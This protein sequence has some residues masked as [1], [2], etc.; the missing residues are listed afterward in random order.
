MHNPKSG[1]RANQWQ[2]CDYDGHGALD[3]IV[4]VGDWSDYGWDNAF[5][6]QGRW[7]RGPLHGYVY[8]IRNT[9]TAGDPQY[10]KAEKISAA[11]KPMDVYTG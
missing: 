4:G 9:G 1:V 7:M 3:L 11:G 6:K 8:L 2:Y 5:D 10:G